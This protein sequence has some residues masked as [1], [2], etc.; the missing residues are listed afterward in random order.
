VRRAGLVAA[1]AALAVLP[2]AGGTAAAAAGVAPPVAH[3]LLRVGGTPRDGNTVFVRGLRWSPGA[4]PAGARLLSFE[5][6]TTWQSCATRTGPCRRA[7]GTTATPF[8]SRHHV[9]G[10]ADV[11]RYLRVTQTAAEVVETDAATFTFK[12]LRAS[13]THTMRAAVLPYRA[14]KAPSIAFVNGFPEGR[15]GSRSERFQ[16]AGAHY[17]GADGKPA[18]RVRVDARPWFRLPK[19]RILATGKLGLGGHRVEARVRNRA[20]RNTRSFSWRVVRLPAPVPC[21]GCFHPPHLDST[22]HPM[23][24]DW[25]IGRVTPLERTGARAVDI[26]DIDGFLTTKAE[27]DAIHATW[28][29]ATLP[30][31]RAFC[32]L[33]LAWED[34]RPDAT[35]G[36]GRFPARTLGNVYFGFPQERWVDVRRL[37][38]LEPMILRRIRMCAAKGFDAVELDDIDSFDPPSTTGFNLTPGD[39]QNFLAF[40]DNAVHEAGMAVLWKNSPLLAW[41]GRRYTDGAVVE[42]CYAFGPCFSAG[43]AGTSAYGITCTGLAGVHPCGWDAFTSKGKWVGEDEYRQDG[44]VCAPGQACTGRHRFSAYCSAVYSPPNGFS[45]M[46]MSDELDGAIFQPCPT[47]T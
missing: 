13:R 19:S 2:A 16:V 33:D 43:L 3:G 14:G 39:W 28:Q 30:H 23:R 26:Y 22:G 36:A 42:E 38:A 44:V 11:G 35:P 40:T 6:A 20:G 9:A 1:L 10:H 37:H 4:L 8:A 24:W 7:A 47:G 46:R 25:Q 32:Y 34:Y 31:P 21:S 29:A 12:V 17:N 41:W 18:V 15:T 5:V 27:I 45:A